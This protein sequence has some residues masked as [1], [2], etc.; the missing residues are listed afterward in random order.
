MEG[1]AADHEAPLFFPA[2]FSVIPAK[3]GIKI[4]VILNECEE[5]SYIPHGSRKKDFSLCSK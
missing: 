3:A 4:V 1:N 2:Y 5:S